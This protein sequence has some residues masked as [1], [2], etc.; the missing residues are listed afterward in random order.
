MK[1][2]KVRYNLDKIDSEGALFNI[3]HGKR[4][5]GKSYQVK[6][7]KAIYLY[8]EDTPR[9]ISSYKKPN[10]VIEECLKAGNKFILMRRFREEIKSVFIEQYFMDVD[11]IGLTN[12]EYNCVTMYKGRIYLSYYDTDNFKLKRGE[13]IG[14]AVALS[15]EQNYAGGSYLDVTDIIFEEFWYICSSFWTFETF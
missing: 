14:Y 2:E 8:L 13:V 7:K 5:N 3:I 12:G 11:I 9:Y 15:T 1:K 6:H 4:S 10:E